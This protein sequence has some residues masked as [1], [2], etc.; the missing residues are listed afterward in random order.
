MET[1]NTE[2]PKLA[3]ASLWTY[4]HTVVL[5]SISRPRSKIVSFALKAF[6]R[7]SLVLIA[8]FLTVSDAFGAT[9]RLWVFEQLGRPHHYFKLPEKVHHASISLANSEGAGSA[10]LDVLLRLA[11]LDFFAMGSMR[12]IF[13]GID[14]KPQQA[15]EFAGEPR[16]LHFGLIKSFMSERGYFG[17]LLFGFIQ[18]FPEARLQW[19][20]L[21]LETG[22]FFS[23]ASPWATQFSLSLLL[24]YASYDR[25]TTPEISARHFST[26]V[27][28][29]ETTKVF[30]YS[31]RF[32]L[33]G[34]TQISWQYQ[35]TDLPVSAEKPAEH[36]LFS[37]GPSALFETLSG[38]YRLALA[39]R[40]WIDRAYFQVGNEG[41]RGYP[42]EIR[43]FPDVNLSWNWAF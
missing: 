21:G 9:R 22:R 43:S 6:G 7:Q 38:T 12:E 14:E 41:E 40:L 32:T 30:W 3:L 13:W 2:R 8:A 39:W 18:F 31:P 10:Q 33:R 17:R 28:T 4:D 15:E 26:W 16:S 27:A 23:P 5:D 35:S 24:P 19:W 1:R 25:L 20:R 29:N 42:S 36:M 11:Y 37:V 34:G